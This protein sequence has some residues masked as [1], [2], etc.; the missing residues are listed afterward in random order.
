MHKR[1]L[2]ENVEPMLLRPGVDT[3]PILT[4]VLDI[5]IRFWSA[6]IRDPIKGQKGY[7]GFAHWSEAGLI[8]GSFLRKW[9]GKMTYL[10]FDGGCQCSG[11]LVQVNMDEINSARK[12]L[13][14]RVARKTYRYGWDY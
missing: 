13:L 12:R 3:I 1:P 8:W 10:G 7:V 2:I 9:T 14:T 5:E 6:V 4:F 11:L